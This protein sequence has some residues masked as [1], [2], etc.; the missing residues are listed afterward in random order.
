[1]VESLNRGLVT[2]GVRRVSSA[3][4]VGATECHSAI[5][6]AVSLCYRRSVFLVL[7][8]AKYFWARREPR[9]PGIRCAMQSGWFP[10]VAGIFRSKQGFSALFSVLK[11]RGFRGLRKKHVFF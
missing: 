2:T 5:R 6:Q 8:V 1:M 9:P 11:A 10:G 3:V 4:V 7:F